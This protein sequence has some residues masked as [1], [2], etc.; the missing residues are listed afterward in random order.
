MMSTEERIKAIEE[1]LRK[2]KR[3]KG[4]EHHL[5][6]LLAKLAKLKREQRVRASRKGGGK[7]FDIKKSGDATVVL[8]GF[9]SVGKSTLLSKITRAKSKIAE[10]DFTTLEVI[11]GVLEYEGAKI[12]VLDIP[13]I[14]GGA[15]KG[16]G[17][18]REIISVARKADLLLI[19]LEVKHP[20]HYG[21]ILGELGGA[22]L[23]LNEDPPRITVEKSSRGGIF[24]NSSVKLTKLK[25]QTII[26]ILNEFGMH[27]GTIT[28]REDATA[29]RL[30]DV[31]E[32]NRAYTPAIIA[33]NKTDLTKGIPEG[34]PEESIGVSAETGKGLEE[35][36]KS[37]Y[38]GLGLI[39]VFTKPRSGEIKWD[40]PM[41][42][43][44][45]VTVEGA[46]K[47]LPRDFLKE[48]RYA[49]VWGK[50]VKFPG[51]R[52]G[53]EHHLRDGDVLQIL[54]R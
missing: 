15:G 3:H 53:L 51:Q 7:G 28:F 18:G 39:K 20:R 4:T 47:K 36:K 40:E 54:K 50:S 43:K 41:I 10:Y 11:P 27:N 24:I 5:G 45:D 33:V 48:F 9:P 30:I 34:F 37:I 29:E 38:D 21:I 49:L 26:A 25:R 1:E 42:L 22:G 35:L 44:K 16:R 31:L 8:V 17:R 14:V 23:R 19:L 52:V 6:L 12:Q 13:G 2:T 32:G 46:C